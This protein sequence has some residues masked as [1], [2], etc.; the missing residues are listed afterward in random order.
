PG[1]YNVFDYGLAQASF[2]KA[3]LGSTRK[4]GFGSTAQRSFNF[5]NNESLQAPCPGQYETEKKMEE[6]YK[7]QH[8]AAF[9][10]T[11]ERLAGSLLAKDSP[12]P[13]SYNVSKICE[14][15][16][17]HSSFSNPRTEGAKK[18]QSCFLSAAPRDA[19][20]LRYDPNVPGPGQYNPSV[21]SSSQM[22]LISSKEDRFRVS[23]N[24]NP[25]PGAYQ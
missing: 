13:N 10:S 6:L 8:T 22:A 17:G 3:V 23:M 4:G 14:K 2:K 5:H 9:K 12:P 16:N 1:S 19:S 20:F 11:T 25:G 24:T 15:V 7:K 18:R 21:K